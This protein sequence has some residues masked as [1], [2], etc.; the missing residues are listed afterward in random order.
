ME[1]VKIVISLSHDEACQVA[2]AI[3]ERIKLLSNV[4]LID[5]LKNIS[6]RIQR[7]LDKEYFG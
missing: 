6:E 4:D 5:R 2:L 7:E 3:K 1:N